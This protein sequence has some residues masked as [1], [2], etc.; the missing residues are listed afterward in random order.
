MLNRQ[1]I[2]YRNSRTSKFPTRQTAG[3]A[4][5]DLSIEAGITLNHDFPEM[6]ST[7]VRV[8]IPEGYVGL[9]IP[10]SSLCSSYLELMNTVGVIDSDFRGEIKLYLRRFLPG[11]TVLPGGTRIAQLIVVPYLS[12]CVYSTESPSKTPRGD[13]GFGSTGQ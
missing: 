7:G 2:F 4:G 8:E 9:V 3:S 13:G 12:T 11:I 5:F 10:R 6:I 1:I